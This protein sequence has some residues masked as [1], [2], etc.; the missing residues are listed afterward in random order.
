MNL[1]NDFLVMIDLQRSLYDRCDENAICESS[2]FEDPRAV[3]IN[4]L[5]SK[6]F[7]SYPNQEYMASLRYDSSL[8]QFSSLCLQVQKFDIQCLIFDSSCVIFD[9]SCLN[10]DS[11][12][13]TFDLRLSC[14]RPACFDFDAPPV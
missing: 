1:N 2:N 4:S 13:L 6:L 12:C 5:S 10:F 3:F 8:S 7:P 11:S 9:S 14:F